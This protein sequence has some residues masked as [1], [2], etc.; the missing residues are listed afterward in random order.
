MIK[1]ET[2][3]RVKVLVMVLMYR[4]RA[5]PALIF[6]IDDLQIRLK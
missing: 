2:E 4:S 1:A 6:G 3:L 5:F